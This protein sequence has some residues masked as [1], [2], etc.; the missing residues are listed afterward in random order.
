MRHGFTQGLW[1]VPTVPR[2][3]RRAQGLPGIVHDPSRTRHESTHA[4]DRNRQFAARRDGTLY[5]G[6]PTGLLDLSGQWQLRAS[7]HGWRGRITG[8]TLWLRRREP[9]ERQER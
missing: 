8:R 6:P 5:I 9:F 7:G 3:N 2:T 1:V 4:I